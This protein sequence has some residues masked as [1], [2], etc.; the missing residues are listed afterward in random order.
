[1]SALEDSLVFSIRAVG[2]PTPEREFVFAK[3]RRWRFDLCWPARK[4][5]V[6]V[7]GGT[8]VNGRHSRGSGMRKDAEKY[9]AA[10]LAGWRVLRF[11]NDMIRDGVALG[12]IE[13]AFEAT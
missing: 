3:P 10:T 5:A 1:M 8:W 13:R 11:T 4:L 2:L 12:T 7:E 6:E 9:N